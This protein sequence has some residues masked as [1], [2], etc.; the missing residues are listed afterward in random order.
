MRR[1]RGAEAVDE[2][3]EEP[4]LAQELP[5]RGCGAHVLGKG[6]HVRRVVDAVLQERGENVSMFSTR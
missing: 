6:R 2:R 4:V 5:E 1:E 3:D